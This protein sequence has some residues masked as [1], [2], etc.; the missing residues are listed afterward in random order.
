MEFA[1]AGVVDRDGEEE[2]DERPDGEFEGE[3]LAEDDAADGFGE[4]PDA[5]GQHEDGFD[6][7]GEAFDL[8]WP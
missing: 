2:N 4:D 6:G 1:G 5:G 8:P 7:G 3:M